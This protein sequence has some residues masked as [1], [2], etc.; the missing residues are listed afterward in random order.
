MSL[1]L[2]AVLVVVAAFHLCWSLGV[3]VPA[4]DEARLAR[5][6]YGTQGVE[7]MPGPVACSLVTVALLFA[8]AWPWFPDGW[9]T[10]LG[11]VVLTLVF[12]GRGMVAYTS[13]W[14]RLA[15]TEPFATLDRRFYAPL[16][17]IL[18][19]GFLILTLEAF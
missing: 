9:L 15:P 2:S 7:R 17:L 3:W 8:A 10:R 14:R 18:G 13:F 4:G 11:L 16:C 1:I 19:A 12:V 5:A 6:V